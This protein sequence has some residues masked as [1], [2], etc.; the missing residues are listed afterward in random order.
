[1]S[2][3][4][5]PPVDSE[6]A[7]RDKAYGGLVDY[8]FKMEEKA[9]KVASEGLSASPTVQ[10]L[11][12]LTAII[13]QAMD[14]QVF[15][16]A[17]K[18]E[19]LHQKGVSPEIACKKGCAYC[20]GTQIMATVPEV[21]RLANWILENFSSE[22]VQALKGRLAEYTPK[23]HAIN[24]SG[25]PRPPMDCPILVDNSC[26]AHPGRPIS[27]RAANSLDVTA[28]INARENW[29]DDIPIPLVGHPLYGGKS[30][31][32]GLRDA[33]KQKG[34]Q[35]PIVEMPIAL[36]IALNDPQAGEKFIAGEPVFEAAVI[37][38]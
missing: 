10:E 26:S 13:E 20:C 21:L 23:V 14:N 1:M 3:E 16:F 7:I 18:L 12:D 17:G 22:Q 24:A 31:G 5:Q 4:S 11:M 35:S 2:P 36:E 25:E 37:E 34:L 29:R 33:M 9:H 27:C 28:C 8:A 19:V 15:R 38:H 32:K 6:Q 30:M